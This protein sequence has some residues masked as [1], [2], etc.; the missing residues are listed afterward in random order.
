MSLRLP[1]LAGLLCL[2]LA[3]APPAA[4]Q[5]AGGAVYKCI[6]RNGVVAYTDRPCDQLQM[7]SAMGAP[8]AAQAGALRIH[9]SRTLQEL[10]SQLAY[11]LQTRDPNRI[12]ELYDWAGV[13]SRTGYA[14]MNRLERLR[15]RINDPKVASSLMPRMPPW[16]TWPQWPATCSPTRAA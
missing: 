14:V 6:G 7:A 13:S 10:M 3:G 11:A 1:C 4:A 9:C 12:A 2:L 15:S 16:P 8:G 5:Q